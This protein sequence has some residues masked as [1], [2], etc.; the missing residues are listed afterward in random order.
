MIMLL[1]FFLFRALPNVYPG[2]KSPEINVT[3]APTVADNTTGL[4]GFTF[5]TPVST[6][7]SVP[8]HKQL[9][10]DISNHQLVLLQK[11]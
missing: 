8:G 11:I 1:F 6:T 3:L 2:P 5:L 9:C 10:L 4:P 7:S